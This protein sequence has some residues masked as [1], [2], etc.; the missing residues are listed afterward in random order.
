M[1]LLHVGSREDRTEGD[2]VLLQTF[3]QLLLLERVLALDLVSDAV[4]FG[5]IDSRRL[6]IRSFFGRQF[7]RYWV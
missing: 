3:L 4:V 6:S 1:H 7:R 2:P 5:N